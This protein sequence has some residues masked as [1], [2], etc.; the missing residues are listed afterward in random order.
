MAQNSFQ[1]LDFDESFIYHSSS[2]DATIMV[3]KYCLTIGEN[4]I[5]F[6]HNRLPQQQ[7]NLQKTTPLITALGTYNSKTAQG[8]SFALSTFD[9]Q[10][11]A[12]L[13]AKFLRILQVGFRAT[14]TFE[15][16]QKIFITLVTSILASKFF[17]F[18]WGP[19]CFEHD[20]LR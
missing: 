4:F 3:A 15:S 20:Y 14:L 18:V 8:N 11:K 1:H 17:T 10:D 12:Q 16:F 7:Y 2:L 13:F 6:I 5:I 19:S 9:K